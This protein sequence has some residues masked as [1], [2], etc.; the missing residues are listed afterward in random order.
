MSSPDPTANT[1]TAPNSPTGSKR[2]ASST[3]DEMNDLI[4]KAKA[5]R[6]TPPSRNNDDDES[7]EDLLEKQLNCSICAELYLHPVLVLPCSHNF[8][9]TYLPPPPPPPPACLE[10]Y[11]GGRDGKG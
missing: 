4:H 1:T 8:C 9:G 11:Y 2:S 10:I 7:L 5:S 6:V 3:A